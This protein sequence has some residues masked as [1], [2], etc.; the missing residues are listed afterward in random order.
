M[1]YIFRSSAKV[2]LTL[3]VLSLRADGYH[4]LQ[5]IVH[6]VGLW[7][8][9][10]FDFSGSPG[11]RFSCN[12]KELAGDSNLCLKAARAWL[13]ASN[14]LNEKRSDFPSVHISLH[15]NIP[16]GA[17]LGGGSGNAAATLMALQTHFPNR[18]STQKLYEIAAKLGADVPLFLRGGCILMEGIGEKLSPLPNIEGWLVVL[19][20][21]QELSTPAVY[22]AWDKL[23]KPSDNATPDFLEKLKPYQN[24]A[25]VARLASALRNDLSYAASEL[26]LN[27]APLITLLRQFGAL[28]AQMTGSGSAVF[29]VFSTE[30]AAQSALQNVCEQARQKNIAL[31][32]ADV[33]PFCQRGIEAIIP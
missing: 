29:G 30:E 31:H 22:R 12:I 8:E 2:N 20:P 9:L 16:T 6:T 27:I 1:K 15:K 17:G 4:E 14:W 28:G 7:D 26:G 18:M 5:S 19:Q 11:L 24:S 23:Q 21:P 3:D 33:A 25:P 13:E 32:F 10:H